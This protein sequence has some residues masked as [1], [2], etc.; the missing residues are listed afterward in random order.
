MLIGIGVLVLMFLRVKSTPQCFGPTSQHWAL[1]PI[2][3]ALAPYGWI[4][5]QVILLPFIIA[6]FVSIQAGVFGKV[7]HYILAL[8]VILQINIAYTPSSWGQEI[9]L[10]PLLGY[11]LVSFTIFFRARLEFRAS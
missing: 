10:I 11:F 5:D 3:L 1:L 8:L 6:L 4:Y 7:G 2:S 9:G